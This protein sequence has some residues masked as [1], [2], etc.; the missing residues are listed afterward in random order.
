MN[1]LTNTH[2]NNSCLHNQTIQQWSPTHGVLS[3][4]SSLITGVMSSTNIIII[5][6]I[7][8]IHRSKSKSTSV[9][10]LVI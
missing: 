3:D 2:N 4:C 6:Y 9:E 8:E 7:N 1:R 5:I 10:D